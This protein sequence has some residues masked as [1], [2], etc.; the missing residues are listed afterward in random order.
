ME[1]CDRSVTSAKSNDNAKS[2]NYTGGANMSGG[3]ASFSGVGAD[4]PSGSGIKSL[5]GTAKKNRIIINDDL[6]SQ[7]KIQYQ[8]AQQ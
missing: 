4:R 7:H 5:Q 8:M 3:G 6:R 2:A 1:N